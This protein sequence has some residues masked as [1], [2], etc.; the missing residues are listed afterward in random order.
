[1]L[2]NTKFLGEVEISESDILTFENG[3]PG[4]PDNKK[5]ALL[6]L[7]ADLPLA[8]LQS[9]EEA[10][11]SFVVAFPFAFKPDYVFDL[12]EEDKEE[13]QIEKEEDVLTYAIVTLKET[14][15]QSTLNLLAPL[16]ININ[17]KLGKQIVLQDSK[18]YP[19]RHTI[20]S[21]TLEGSA[22]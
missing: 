6:S 7:D 8:L 9:T 14:F 2:V 13:L 1:M 3:L 19:L 12:S 5:F 21:A 20:G 4:F 16:V 18:V 15:N 17:K 11:I 10:A 22:K